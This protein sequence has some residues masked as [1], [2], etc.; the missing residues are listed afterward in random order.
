[1]S[2]KKKAA[3][4]AAKSAKLRCP[5]CQHGVDA[6]RFGTGLFG[7]ANGCFG[8][9]ESR[10]DKGFIRFKPCFCDLTPEEALVNA[11]RGVSAPSDPNDLLREMKS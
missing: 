11:T 1:M 4:R 6:H 3:K 2:A 10:D 9:S 5:K 7:T 8:K